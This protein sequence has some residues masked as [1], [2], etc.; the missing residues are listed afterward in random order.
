[1]TS[2]RYALHR[3]KMPKVGDQYSDTDSRNVNVPHVSCATGSSHMAKPRLQ[4]LGNRDS[5]RADYVHATCV[6]GGGGHFHEL[7]PKHPTDQ[8]SVERVVQIR[9]SFI[10][11]ASDSEILLPII[12]SS[13]ASTAAPLHDEP[14]TFGP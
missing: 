3:V 5:Q 13:D 10:Q 9:K 14:V 1:M 4:Q 12:A 6:H 7:L 8:D 2:Q 11:A